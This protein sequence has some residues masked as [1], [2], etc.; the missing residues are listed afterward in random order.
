MILGMRLLLDRVAP[1]G[2][3]LGEGPT[4]VPADERLV[5][6]DILESAVHW[7]APGDGSTGRFST[8]R[9]VTALAPTADGGYV[10]ATETGLGRL[11]WESGAIE[12]IA[13]IAAEGARM[14]DGKCDPAGRFVA[15]SMALNG[16]DP[17]GEVVALE[18]SLETRTLLTG[19]RISN[20]LDWSPD[21]RTM[22]YVDTGR[23]SLDS[24]AYDVDLGTIGV[25]SRLVELDRAEGL[26]DGLAADSEGCVWVAV[27]YA[28]EVRRYSPRGRLLTVVHAPTAVVTS[29]CFGG[30]DL[31][32]LYV[33][34]A[35][36]YVDPAAG[37]AD[38]DGGALF[39][40]EVSVAGLPTRAFGRAA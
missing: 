14:N 30:V 3:R 27:P 8:D 40:V 31:K 20:G 36:A 29:C 18:P 22:Y 11:T 5:W 24:F 37:E 23:G 34:S 32:T 2:C 21:G 35:A 38:E 28:G 19:V 33:T 16:E 1:S 7:F 13:E 10:A 12:Q 17:L 25:R 39:A 15:G 6:V 9:P 26:F 4:W